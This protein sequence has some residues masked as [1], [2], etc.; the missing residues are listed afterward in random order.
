ML[1]MTPGARVRCVMSKWGDRPHWQFEGVYLG[2][3]EHGDWVGCPAGTHYARPGLAFD[4]HAASVTLAPPGGWYAA[5]FHDEGVWCDTYVDITTPPTLDPDEHG[6][7]LR[8]IDLD[9]D[10]IRMADPAADRPP[11]PGVT[12]GPGE[13]FVDDE[14]EFVE[15]RVAFGYP[16]EVVAAA[17]TACAGVRRRVLAGEAPFDTAT[18]R[19]WLDRL[20]G[21]Q[22]G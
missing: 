14:D 5:T 11:P 21:L 17:E 22:R 4:S 1:A 12:A 2:A 6:G 8:A 13:V 16:P 3:D 9:L 10:V 7:V 20:A 18:A 15:H 19:R